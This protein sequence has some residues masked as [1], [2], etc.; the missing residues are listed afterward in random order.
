M[1]SRSGYHPATAPP[2]A[3]KRRARRCVRRRTALRARCRVVGLRSTATVATVQLARRAPDASAAGAHPRSRWASQ[4][5]TIHCSAHVSEQK[6]VAASTTAQTQDLLPAG[7]VGRR[8]LL[9]EQPVRGTAPRWRWRKH[10]ARGADHPGDDRKPARRSGDTL[11]WPCCWAFAPGSRP[12]SGASKPPNSNAGINRYTPYATACRPYRR[13]LV[14]STAQVSPTLES[15][16]TQDMRP[17]RALWLAAVPAADA[18]DA[19]S[20]AWLRTVRGGVCT[21][22][23]TWLRAVTRRTPRRGRPRWVWPRAADQSH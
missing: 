10:R 18:P 12:S 19:R 23:Q 16:D 7:P 11:T 9:D 14:V 17:R 6:A 1:G 20:A 3:P 4:H 2:P 22:C 5:N 15:R 13:E 8:E 21:E